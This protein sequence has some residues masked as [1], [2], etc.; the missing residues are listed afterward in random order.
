MKKLI[1]AC[2]ALMLCAGAF[3]QEKVYLW[4]KK[5]GPGSEKVKVEDVPTAY[6]VELKTK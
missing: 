4:P 5:T 6:L 2:I 1:T 3:A